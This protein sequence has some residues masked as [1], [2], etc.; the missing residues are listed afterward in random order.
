VLG[1]LFDGTLRPTVGVALADSAHHFCL[2]SGRG[3]GKP[4]RAALQWLQRKKRA[5]EI[6]WAKC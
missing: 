2:Q 6:S 3:A 4:A 5:R 1:R